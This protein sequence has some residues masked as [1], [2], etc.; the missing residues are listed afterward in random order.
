MSGFDEYLWINE[1]SIKTKFGNIN[2]INENIPAS[3][4]I[5]KKSGYSND[6]YFNDLIANENYDEL[7]NMYDL[8]EINRDSNLFE[9]R[10]KK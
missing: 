8:D 7:F 5:V 3:S 6:N 10:M 2:H 9:G 1:L 4:V